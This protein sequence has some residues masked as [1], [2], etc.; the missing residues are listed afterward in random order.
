MDEGEI[1]TRSSHTPP[2]N[3]GR[4]QESYDCMKGF[5]STPETDSDF[6]E[7]GHRRKTLHE[8]GL[9][10]RERAEKREAGKHFSM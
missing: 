10:F 6:T 9:V 3:D 5:T 8:G 1:V 2:T 4:R 7:K